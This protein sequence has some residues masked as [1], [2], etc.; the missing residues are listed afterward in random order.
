MTDYTSI[1]V[2]LFGSGNLF[3]F[4][5]V[6]ICAVFA[7]LYGIRG[8]VLKFFLFILI[9]GLSFTTTK[10]VTIITLLIFCFYYGKKIYKGIKR[11]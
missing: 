3:L 5:F 11:E 10:S 9:L 1:L 4:S 6:L 7:A 8:E 2:A